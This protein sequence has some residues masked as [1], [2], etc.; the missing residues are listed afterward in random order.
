[1]WIIEEV[2]PQHFEVC[3]VPIALSWIVKRLNCWLQESFLCPLSLPRPLPTPWI[4]CLHSSAA[5]ISPL[6]HTSVNVPVPFWPLA[7]D[8]TSFPCL[9]V[10]IE[11]LPWAGG[12]ADLV[13]E[14]EKA[15]LEL[16]PQFLD[17]VLCPN[18]QASPFSLSASLANAC[19]GWG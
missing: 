15:G 13:V 5:F 8:T 10:N 11:D 14:N 1:M 19:K 12:R 6:F 4:H 18:T 17:A 3:V 7:A 16:P 2:V 9:V